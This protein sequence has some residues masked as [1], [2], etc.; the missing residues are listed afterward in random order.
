[1]ARAHRYRLPHSAAAK[2][3]PDGL[4]STGQAEGYRR[5]LVEGSARASAVG[6]GRSGEVAGIGDCFLEIR[7]WP[8]HQ[9]LFLYPHHRQGPLRLHPHLYLARLQHRLQRLHGRLGLLPRIDLSADHLLRY[10]YLWALR[11]QPRV[12]VKLLARSA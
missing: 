12:V 9:L 5:R 1:M 7:D 10:R 4:G 11:W 8:H 2:I 3:D 6:F